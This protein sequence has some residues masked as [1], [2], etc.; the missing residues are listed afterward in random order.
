VGLQLV[1]D[2]DPRRGPSRQVRTTDVDQQRPARDVVDRPKMPPRIQF[3]NRTHRP[4]CSRPAP[5]PFR[6]RVPMKLL[7]RK[8]TLAFVLLLLAGGFARAADLAGHWTAGF[9][10]QIGPQKYAYAFA[11]EGDKLTGKAKFEHSM[12]KGE[13]VLSN[14]KIT[15]EEVSFTEVLR[16]DGNEIV[17]TY[18][19]KFVG[20]EIHL[21]REV[22][23]FAV[24]DV[25]LKRA[26]E[27]TTAAP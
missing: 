5:V 16:F 4:S 24:E 19:G 27:L 26:K 2:V 10:S 23:E 18:K 3:S 9:D 12:G 13:N 8:L 15:G 11:L 7:A 14:I 25:V 1:L 6:H 20:E 21:K 22:G 17:V